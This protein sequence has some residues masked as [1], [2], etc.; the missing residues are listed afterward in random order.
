MKKRKL[1]AL[2]I[3]VA[4]CFTLNVTA[5]ATY[6]PTQQVMID[7]FNVI[8][9]GV[10][11]PTQEW[12]WDNGVYS[13]YFSDVKA[14]IYTGYYFTGAS[15]LYLTL[16]NITVS[17]STQFMYQLICL[18]DDT[19]SSPLYKVSMSSGDSNL[20]ERSFNVSNNYD[21]CIFIRT[22]NYESADGDIQI[23]YSR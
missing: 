12:D 18:T 23:S 3:A 6:E 10:D 21:Y 16:D 5:S 13:S 4:L 9:R 14:G 7:K 2:I 22:S 15:V 11:I 1:V 8:T 20:I 19:Y 17:G